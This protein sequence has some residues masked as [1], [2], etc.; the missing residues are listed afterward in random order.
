METTLKVMVF[1][2]LVSY[3]CSSRTFS[4]GGMELL[5]YTI[6]TPAKKDSL[7]LKELEFCDQNLQSNDIVSQLLCSSLCIGNCF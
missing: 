4:L 5:F 1:Y 6:I 7:L 3:P 2:R